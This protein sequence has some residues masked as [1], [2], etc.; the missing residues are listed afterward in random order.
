M[1]KFIMLL[2]LLSFISGQFKVF[3]KIKLTLILSVT[4]FFLLIMHYFGHSL[5]FIGNVNF[6]YN[7]SGLLNYRYLFGFD[8]ISFL[9]S[10]LASL[11][12]IFSL[13]SKNNKS[14]FSPLVLISCFFVLQFVLSAQNIMSYIF[15]SEL[16]MI[17]ILILANARGKKSHKLISVFGLSHI[18]IMIGFSL[19]VYLNEG[20]DI[21]LEGLRIKQSIVY[22]G[23]TIKIASLLILSGLL[24]RTEFIP[25]ISIKSEISKCFGDSLGIKIYY[26]ISLAVFIGLSRFIL[27]FLSHEYLNLKNIFLYIGLFSTLLICIKNYREASDIK[28]LRNYTS[29]FSNLIL[30]GLFSVTKEGYIVSVLMTLLMLAITAYD[31]K[32]ISPIKFLF[33]FILV[34]LPGFP[35][36]LTYIYLLKTLLHYDYYTMVMSLIIISF[37][38]FDGVLVISKSNYKKIKEE[39]N[40][41]EV[42]N[43][44]QIY[45]LLI[46]L[47][48]I[49]CF[50]IQII[51]FLD[52]VIDI[53]LN[54]MA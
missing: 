34:A 33:A 24:L 8:S 22:H 31:K 54:K 1:F 42:S 40:G 20:F 9:M 27:P 17:I 10:S 46:L 26:L 14:H 47:L 30:I 52:P 44:L 23:L 11:S 41:L 43:K 16:L 4:T 37:M 25:K 45:I 39:F 3:N 32:L 21:S 51:E 19:L 36:L 12:I 2:P 29:I 48:I 53:F 18:S 38:T 13:I 15:C 5:E 50:G 28:R 35:G 6:S 7:L 49:G